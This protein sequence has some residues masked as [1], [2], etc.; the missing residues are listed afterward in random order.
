MQTDVQFR[1]NWCSVDMNWYWLFNICSAWAVTMPDLLVSVLYTTPEN[2]H[3][4]IPLWFTSFMLQSNMIF[5]HERCRN[6]PPHQLTVI[7]SGLLSQHPFKKRTPIMIPTTQ[8]AF[9]KCWIETKIAVWVSKCPKQQ[10]Y[11]LMTLASAP[12]RFWKT[13]VNVNMQQVQR[14]ECV[15][16]KTTNK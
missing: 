1:Q 5:Q 10:L 11:P 3:T 15:E 4:V 9:N 13:H 6:I 14:N 8:E 16:S 12:S 2:R 7:Y